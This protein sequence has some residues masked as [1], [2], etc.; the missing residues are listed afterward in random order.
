MT[1]V[2]LGLGSNIGDRR[3]NICKALELLAE[4]VQVES[5]SSFYETEPW[6]FRD[7]PMFLNMACQICTDLGPKDLLHLAKDI[8]KRLGRT[9]GFRNAPRIIDIDIL[10]YHN[11][12]LDEPDLTLPHPRLSE[13]AFVLV[14]LAEIAPELV[15]PKEGKTMKQMASQAKGKDTVHPWA[16]PTPHPCQACRTDAKIN[17]RPLAMTDYEQ[18]WRLWHLCKM[19]LGESYSRAAVERMTVHDPELGLVAELNGVI[20]GAVIGFL[21]GAHG[22]V[23]NHAVDPRCRG[24][25]IGTMLYKEI[26]GKLIAKGANEIE[27]MVPVASLDGRK[28]FEDMGFADDGRYAFM[29]KQYPE[30]KHRADV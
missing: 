4:K 10:L 11:R 15:H 12:V 6:G 26:E 8:E 1:E 18:A 24:R 22:R 20:I 5:V 7:Q 29:V 27:I 13:R 2:Y 16:D 3:A 25:G 14:P 9:P 17:I 23:C 30:G 19:P 28:Y 21:H